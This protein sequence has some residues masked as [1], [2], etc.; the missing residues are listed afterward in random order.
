MLHT[1]DDASY[2]HVQSYVFDNAVGGDVCAINSSRKP[3]Y[4][5]SVPLSPH[6]HMHGTFK[7]HTCEPT[8][9]PIHLQL[10]ETTKP[11]PRGG[12]GQAAAGPPLLPQLS[13][14]QHVQKP[15]WGLP[16]QDQGHTSGTPRQTQLAVFPLPTLISTRVPCRPLTYVLSPS[17]HQA[18]GP[19]YPQAPIRP[20]APNVLGPQAS[21]WPPLSSGP[22]Q[23]LAPTIFRPQSGYD[24][25]CL[26][27]PSGTWPPFRHLVPLSTRP[28]G[29][30]DPGAHP[31]LIHNI[32]IAGS[33]T[34]PSPPLK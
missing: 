27:H 33:T 7:H 34:S 1:Y 28:Y 11:M 4:H 6:L 19:Q 14:L 3:S 9:Q 8:I 12:G 18:L 32:V 24:P 26:W 13:V 30:P 5:P 23:A 15:P 31:P 22:N 2:I 25:H 17:P 10:I 29:H 21:S 16:C 20:L